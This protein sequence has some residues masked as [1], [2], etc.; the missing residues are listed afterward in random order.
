MSNV[1]DDLRYT[2]EHEWVRLDDSGV[3]TCGITDH[4]QSMLEE[5]VFV[6]LPE[7]HRQVQQRDHIAVIESE[8]SVLDVHAPVSG[9]IIE[10]NAALEETP[11]L[12]NDD[13]YGDGWLFRIALK[14]KGKAGNLL[15]A[16]EYRDYLEQAENEEEEEEDEDEEEDE[17]DYDE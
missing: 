7:S 10:I 2:K 4:A 8:K 3:A 12:I 5:I 17:Y 13:P 14:G 1:P 11:E 9:K 16:D 15:D 6:E